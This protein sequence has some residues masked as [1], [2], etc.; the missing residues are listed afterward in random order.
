MSQSKLQVNNVEVDPGKKVKL[1]AEIGARAVKRLLSEDG[2][3]ALEA[4]KREL[5]KAVGDGLN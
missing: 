1:Y 3:E 4:L 5:G 2:K